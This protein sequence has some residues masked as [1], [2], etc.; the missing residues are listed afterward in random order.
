[1]LHG[2]LI[3]LLSLAVGLTAALLVI[4]SRDEEQAMGALDKPAPARAVPRDSSWR[5]T[6]FKPSAPL[7]RTE[8]AA[9]VVGDDIYVV[10]GFAPPSGESSAVV[11][12]LRRGKWSRVRQLPVALNHAAAVGYRGRVYVIG[13]YASPNGLA[14]PVATL[15]RY[16]P[17]RNRWD[18]LPGMPTARAALA[19]GALGGK[20]YAAGGADGSKALDTFEIYDVAKR[21]WSR[22]PDLSVAREHTG[23]AVAG[24]R[25]YVVAGRNPTNT[26]VFERYDPGTRKWKRL[27]DVPKPRGGNGAAG[28]GGSIFA[29]GGEEGAGTIAEVDRYD[30]RTGKWTR[31]EDMPTPRHGLGVVPLGGKVWVIEGGPQPGLAYSNAVEVLGR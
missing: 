1:M 10:G 6:K 7:A 4:Q 21:R 22:G 12:R 5:W 24:G 23:G 15:L 8:V 25:F 28:I 27:G 26:G 29:V 20:L 30:V 14:Q 18:R 31:V 9:A 3:A 19:V 13:G 16:D 2:R 11:T 17:K